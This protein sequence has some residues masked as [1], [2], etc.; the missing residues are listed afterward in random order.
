MDLTTIGIKVGWAVETTAGTRPTTFTQIARCKKIAGVSLTTDKIDVT[1]LEDAIKKYAAGLK[2]TGGDW[3]LTF[4][5]SDA[6][7]TAWNA[8]ITAYETAKAA[9]KQT[10][11]V[12]WIPNMAKSFYIIAEPGDIPM[13]DI[14]VSNPLEYEI[15]N[16]INDF[17]GL[18]TAI[19]PTVGE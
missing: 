17:K 3:P 14:D 1:A 18:D 5:A 10:W 11:F 7:V 16:V 13:P 4:G 2:D 12:V 6:F 8:L 9:G 15:S 19:E